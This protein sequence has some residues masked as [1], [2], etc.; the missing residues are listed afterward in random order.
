[1]VDYMNAH[2]ID[3]LFD[4]QESRTEE[5]DLTF[6][7]NQFIHSYV[8]TVVQSEDGALAGVYVSSDRTRREKLYFVDA[9][10]ILHAFRSVG[11][12]YPTKQIMK[13]N[14]KTLQWEEVVE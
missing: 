2:R 12:D 11:K 13:R 5:R 1:M 14:E 9:S 4:L 10:H 6:L 3:E 8:F 7:C